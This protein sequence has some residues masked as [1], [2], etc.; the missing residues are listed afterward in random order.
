MFYEKSLSETSVFKY[1]DTMSNSIKLNTV[2]KNLIDEKN[3]AEFL[4]AEQLEDVFYK[5]RHK[6]FNFQ[7]KFAV[8]DLF[9]KGIIRLVYNP[10]VKLTVAVPFFK[11]KMVNGGFGVIINVSNYVKIDKDDSV[12]IDPTVLFTLMLSGAFLLCDKGVLPYSGVPELYGDLFTSI[13]A[14]SANLSLINKDK[15]KFVM[16]K[17]MYI[18]L[19]VSEDRASE[20]A[21]KE[22]RNIDKYGLNQLD[23]GFP[24]AVFKD[25]DTLIDH[26]RKT[27]P[28][29][30]KLTFGIIFEKWMRTYGEVSAFGIEY[31]PS[32]LTMFIGLMTNANS[33]VNIKAIE[34][35]ANKNSSKLT[36]LFNKIEGMVTN[37]ADRQK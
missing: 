14:K 3:G 20:A 34:K 23:L 6:S 37:L 25:L 31:I 11:Y 28:E 29:F 36:L 24:A 15:I 18:Q 8:I 22:I 4:T 16:T 7:A 13:I 27:F 12:N 1:T 33:L 5:I 30:E 35:D 26:M 17:F 21:K 32:F 9:N 2:I 19:G 10:K